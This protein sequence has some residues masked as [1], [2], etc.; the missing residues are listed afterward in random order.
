MT[1]TSK[2][3]FSINDLARFGD[4]VLAYVK[5]ISVA[6]AK[7]IIGEAEEIPD[8]IKLFCLFSAN[9]TPLAI[10]DSQT[11]AVANAFEHDLEPIS[12]H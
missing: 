11:S 4:G 6:D 1:Q 12:L 2:D 3:Q 8:N 5:A 9:G 10:S 7:N